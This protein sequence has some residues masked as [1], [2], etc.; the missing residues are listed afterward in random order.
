MAVVALGRGFEFKV[1]FAEVCPSDLPE[2]DAMAGFGL[3]QGCLTEVYGPASSG[4]P[5]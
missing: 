2:V 1:G 3:P 4:A 5:A